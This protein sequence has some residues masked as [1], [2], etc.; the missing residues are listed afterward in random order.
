MRQKVSALIVG[1]SAVGKEVAARLATNWPPAAKGW[2]IAVN[3]AAV[4]ESMMEAEFFGCER[5]AFSGAQR[6]DFVAE[7]AGALVDLRTDA[8]ERTRQ[9]PSRPAGSTA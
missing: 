4:P 2:F 6:L 9:L 8:F 5:D 1:G 3:C 7:S